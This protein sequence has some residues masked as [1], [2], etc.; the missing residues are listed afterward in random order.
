MKPRDLA[1]DP[2]AIEAHR[3]RRPAAPGIARAM[4][5][6]THGP[7]MHHESARGGPDR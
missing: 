4:L 7:A 5:R 1:I 6:R 2:R 3:Q